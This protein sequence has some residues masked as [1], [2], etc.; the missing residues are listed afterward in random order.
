MFIVKGPKGEMLNVSLVPA[1]SVVQLL[2][3]CS[4]SVGEGPCISKQVL[5][6]FWAFVLRGFQINSSQ[7][8]PLEN[9]ASRPMPCLLHPA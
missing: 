5:S 3:C 7:L 2:D 8:E 9:T 1:R 6:K 4:Y